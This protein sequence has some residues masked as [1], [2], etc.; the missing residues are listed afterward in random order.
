MGYCLACLRNDSP[1]IN[2]NEKENILDIETSRYAYKDS[3]AKYLKD[4]IN[5]TNIHSQSGNYS[6]RDRNDQNKDSVATIEQVEVERSKSKANSNYPKTNSNNQIHI[7]N[8]KFINEVEEQNSPVSANKRNSSSL[9]QSPDESPSG[10]TETENNRTFRSSE[11]SVSI[12]N[13]D[14]E[15]AI[16][17]HEYS[18][19]TF[20]VVI[21]IRDKPYLYLPKLKTLINKLK[22][23]PIGKAFLELENCTY[24]FKSNYES[25]KALEQQMS[26]YSD[27]DTK[28]NK[29]K[30]SKIND[31][32]ENTQLLWSENLYQAC[33]DHLSQDQDIAEILKTRLTKICN[34]DTDFLIFINDGIMDIETKVLVM[35]L[36]NQN[37]RE[38]F[39]CKTFSI[40]AVGASVINGDM[41]VRTLL[42]LANY[43]VSKTNIYNK[44]KTINNEINQL[45]EVNINKAKMKKLEN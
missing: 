32:N 15:L 20:N 13:V 44:R 9:K 30:D 28:I 43:L 6:H 24:N 4:S 34:K 40:G 16:N 12:E 5:L 18:I 14:D 17:F 25:I 22:F 27:F 35:L 21:N 31:L 36:D 33:S 7:T 2:S 45:R 37:F 11:N 29:S 26:N 8:E 19:N 10:R 23:D 38:D 39:F 3:M 42:V 41:K 1:N